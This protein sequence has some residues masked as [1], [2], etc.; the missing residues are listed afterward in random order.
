MAVL[1]SLVAIMT[2]MTRSPTI[3]LSRADAC[4]AFFAPTAERAPMRLP[5]RLD[6]ATPIPK[7]SVLRNYGDMIQKYNH[8]QSNVYVLWSVVMITDC[9]ASGSE[10]KRPAASATISKAALEF[11]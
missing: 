3:I 2:V 9:A 8:S 10:P 7:G 6:A 11:A 4:A 5:T 1:T